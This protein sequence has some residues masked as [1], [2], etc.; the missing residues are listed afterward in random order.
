M[1]MHVRV[2]RFV[3]ILVCMLPLSVFAQRDDAAAREL[4]ADANRE[5]AQ[6]NIPPLK[7]SPRLTEAAAAHTEAMANKGTLAHVLPGE[8][9]LS[10]RLAAAN[11]RVGGFAENVAFASDAPSV[12]E[13]WMHSPGHRAN[14]LNPAY[15][16][17]GIAAYRVGD[18]LYAT[19]DFGTETKFISADDADLR[20]RDAIA[21][22]RQRVHLPPLRTLVP[23]GRHSDTCSAGPIGSGGV[24]PGHRR[25]N[26]SYTQTDPSVLPDVLKQRVDDA[27]YTSYAISVC[28]Q[29]Q[30]GFTMMAVET[31]FFD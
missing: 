19:Q 2:E 7:W 5:R 24:L 6:R 17:V 4:F 26:V 12:H 15:D 11:A 13:G 29:Q 22:E 9:E 8:L 10:H 25:S 21:K 30:D 31:A 23:G 28:Q 3:L 1:N 16:V 18:R 14:L 20:I 27:R